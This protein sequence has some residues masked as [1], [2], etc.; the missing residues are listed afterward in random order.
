MGG[1]FAVALNEEKGPKR[2]PFL[3]L[4][5]MR[6]PRGEQH[7]PISLSSRMTYIFFA[8]FVFV[9]IIFS[10]IVRG[11][12]DGMPFLPGSFASRRGH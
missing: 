3:C 8:F 2:R 4:L 10:S 6:P 1:T 12:G 9:A 7:P 5:P 11:L